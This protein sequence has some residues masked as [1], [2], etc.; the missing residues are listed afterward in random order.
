MPKKAARNSFYYFMVDFKEEQR[1]KG[2]VYANMA[3]V[4]NAAG[5]AWTVSLK[6][7]LL[8]TCKT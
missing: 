1:K 4:A 8:A 6:I 3:E 7:I 5:P 2:I